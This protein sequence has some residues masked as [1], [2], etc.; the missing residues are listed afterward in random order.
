MRTSRGSAP[1]KPAATMPIRDASLFVE[2][3]GDGYPLLLM[4]GGPGADH[5]SMLPFR[6]CAEQL[7]LVFYDH[8]CNGRS[9]GGLSGWRLPSGGLRHDGLDQL[10]LA[11]EVA[12]LAT[13]FCESLS[14]R[15][16]SWNWPSVSSSFRPRTF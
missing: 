6:R 5:W 4:H 8:R 14:T 3:I 13:A 10:R 7:T 15:C 16:C 1:T 11:T 9:Q 12:M 2:V